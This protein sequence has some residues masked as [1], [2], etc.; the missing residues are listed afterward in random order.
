MNGK[1]LATF[2]EQ[3]WDDYH[4]LLTYK[5]TPSQEMAQQLSMQFDGLFATTTGYDMLDQRI[6]MTRIKKN[7]LL[8]VLDHPFLPW[9]NNVSELGARVQARIRDINFQTVSENGTK[10]KDTFTTIVQTAR[11]MSVN[12]YKY[13]YDRVTKKFEMPSLANMILLKAQQVPKST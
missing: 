1:I 4:A 2:L 5:E 11:K 7:A 9:H 3:F 6:A 13:I 10:S 12:V 8:L